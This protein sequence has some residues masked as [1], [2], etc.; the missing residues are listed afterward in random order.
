MRS[1]R[2]D[3]RQGK[4][5]YRSDLAKLLQPK[6]TSFVLTIGLVSL[7][8]TGC[9]VRNASDM[10]GRVVVESKEARASKRHLL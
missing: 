2:P 6:L 5:R 4:I 10:S 3:S 7:D 9:C 1:T 8:T